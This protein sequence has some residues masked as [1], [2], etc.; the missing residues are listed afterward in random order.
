MFQHQYLPEMRANRAIFLE[1]E[2]KYFTDGQ[3]NSEVL[4]QYAA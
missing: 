3:L 1:K 4:H 2:N